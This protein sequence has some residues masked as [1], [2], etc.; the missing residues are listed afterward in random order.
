MLNKIQDKNTTRGKKNEIFKA[1]RQSKYGNNIWQTHSE[2]KTLSL[3]VGIGCG[4]TLMQLV[5]LMQL[6]MP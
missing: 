6:G 1:K 3:F 2:N 4:V 5:W